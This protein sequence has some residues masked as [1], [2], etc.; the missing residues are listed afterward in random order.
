VASISIAASAEFHSDHS[1][2]LL[3]SSRGSRS[4]GYLTRMAFTI[5]ELRMTSGFKGRVTMKV[6]PEEYASVALFTRQDINRVMLWGL[7]IKAV[8]V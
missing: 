6:S 7:P 3:E 2:P 4:L 1:I 5:Q 8:R